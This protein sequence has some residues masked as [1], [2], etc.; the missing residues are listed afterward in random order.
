MVSQDSQEGKIATGNQQLTREKAVDISPMEVFCSYSHE[1]E[2][3]RDKLEKY[4]SPLKRQRYITTWYDRRILAG[5]KWAD[6]IDHH[7]NTAQ[8]ILLLI[9]PDFLASED[10]STVEV[11]RAIERDE[12]GEARVIPIILRPIYWQ[13]EPFGKLQALPKDAKPVIDWPILDDAL[14]DVA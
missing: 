2:A 13:E 8:I 12:R 3:L 5:Q 10:C 1:D 11:K 7:L 6:E 4:L 9:S 14:F